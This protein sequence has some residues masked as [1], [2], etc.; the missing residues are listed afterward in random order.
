MRRSGA[1]ETA[2]NRRIADPGE[3]QAMARAYAALAERLERVRRVVATAPADEPATGLR[4]LAYPLHPGAAWVVNPSPHVT[5][6]VEAN[7]SLRLPFGRA[8]ASRVRI[9]I[10]FMGPDDRAWVWYGRLGTLK[11]AYHLVGYATDEYGNPIGTL[12]SDVVRTADEVHLVR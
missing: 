1:F 3:R 9:I 10:E 12:L 4:L 7:E 6:Q 2:L 8:P 5:A 11:V